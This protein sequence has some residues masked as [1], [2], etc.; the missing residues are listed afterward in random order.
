MH[1][2]THVESDDRTCPIPNPNPSSAQPCLALALA[3]ALAQPLARSYMLNAVMRSQMGVP[4]S[5]SLPSP[6]QKVSQNHVLSQRAG[7]P[8]RA[9]PSAFARLQSCSM[10]AAWE[11]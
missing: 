9:S 1:A 7:S 2:C 6:P 10:D 5:R 11:S 3:L 4:P 8:V